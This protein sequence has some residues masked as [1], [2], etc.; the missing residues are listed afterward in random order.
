MRGTL[1]VRMQD[2]DGKFEQV[3]HVATVDMGTRT[4][5]DPAEK[6]VMS[7]MPGA[8][9]VCVRHGFDFIGFCELKAL[10]K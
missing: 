6:L 2:V 9:E 10:E 5:W 1:L 4:V 3:D 8:F 7:L